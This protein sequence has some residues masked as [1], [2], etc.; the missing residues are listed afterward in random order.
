MTRA[1]S[2]RRIL[3]RQAT[4]INI[5]SHFQ[6]FFPPIPQVKSHTGY[7]PLFHIIKSSR[8]NC[9]QIPLS[10]FF[11][12]LELRRISRPRVAWQY[13]NRDLFSGKKLQQLNRTDP[14]YQASAEEEIKQ[15]NH[16][17][18]KMSLSSF[19]FARLSRRASSPGATAGRERSSLRYGSGAGQQSF[20]GI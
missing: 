6:L 16:N 12:N 8:Q 19:V 15:I 4:T 5:F 17:P 9:S 18:A 10:C 3:R 2:K 20:N 7:V 11:L 13:I 1:R 14:Y